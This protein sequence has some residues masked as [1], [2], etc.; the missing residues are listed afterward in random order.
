MASKG[1]AIVLD[2]LTF[3]CAASST[4]QRISVSSQDGLNIEGLLIE[5]PILLISILFGNSELLM[6]KPFCQ[7]NLSIFL[8]FWRSLELE[9]LKFKSEQPDENR[10]M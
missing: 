2:T 9:N 3:R 1:A 8:E 7:L 6:G 4:S 5:C 10:K